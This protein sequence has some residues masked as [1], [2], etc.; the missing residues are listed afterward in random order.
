M[1]RVSL[2][3]SPFLLG[4]ENFEKTFDRAAKAAGDGYPPYNIEQLSDTSWRIVLAV[5]GFTETDLAVTREDNQLVVTG[6]QPDASD[7]TYLHKGIGTRAFQRR[8]ILA[9]G[10]EVDGA[11]LTSGLL[12]IDLVRP[13]VKPEVQ[14]IPITNSDA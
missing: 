8:F 5:A 4:F 11:S 7:K 6:T 9:D 14:T 10:M 2:F 1:N 13:V 3:S 12:V